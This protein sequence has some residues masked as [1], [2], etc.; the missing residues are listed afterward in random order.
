MSFTAYRSHQQLLF[1]FCAL[2]IFRCFIESANV[3]SHLPGFEGKLPFYLE[4]G[5]VTIDE[6]SG[7]Q[8]FYYFIESEKTPKEDPL[9]LW[10]TG[11]PGCSSLTALT[12]EVGP[13][14]FEST[15]YNASEQTLPTFVSNPYSWTKLSSIIFVD[16]PVGTGFSFSPNSEN[17]FS[18]DLL[19]SD[20]VYR[21]IRKWFM[22]HPHFLSNPFYVAGDSY[23]GKIIPVVA[24]KIADGNDAGQQPI[25]N[26]K[27][28]IAGN[29]VTDDEDEYRMA[30]AYGFGVGMISFDLLLAVKTS[31]VG[32]KSYVHRT[33]PD[34]AANLDI[35]D[36]FLKEISMDNILYPACPMDFDPWKKRLFKPFRR[37]YLL[38]GKYDG[39]YN[40][41][42]ALT[43][44]C[45]NY[46]NY[47]VYY[48]AN[49]PAV[50]EALHIKEG[51]VQ[52]WVRCNFDMAYNMSIKSSAQYHLNFLR[53]E[54]RALVYS[55]DHD[56]LVPFL[57]TT[58]WIRSLNLPIRDKWRSW[59]VDDQVA[60]Y[61]ELYS[62][63]LT[64]ATV[65]GGSHT[66]PSNKPKQ[67]FALFE[68]WLSGKPL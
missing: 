28:Y 16:C 54:Y 1:A 29:P 2:L 25:L 48:W 47:L 67:C 10:L 58:K 49:N 12:T 34:C 60:G 33:K 46:A 62:V 4:T 36:G 53:R 31:C 26:L 21:F 27:G 32:E 50:R 37:S 18:D 59:H 64:Y 22:D 66:A 52:E 40:P 20:E 39:L 17:Y 11:G 68:R 24:E 3:V 44:N 56:L 41:P 65:K 19:F 5:Y 38:E 13:L 55:G 30:V 45:P 15:P 8:M 51:T 9:L 42:P 7:A 63:N 43:P 61:T 23:G 57:S 35:F 14:L 6:V